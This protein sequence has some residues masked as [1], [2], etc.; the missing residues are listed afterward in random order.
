MH[1]DSYFSHS[2]FRGVA[3]RLLT[4]IGLVLLVVLGARAQSQL[5]DPNMVQG[6]PRM[7]GASANFVAAAD[8][9][10]SAPFGASPIVSL[11]SEQKVKNASTNSTALVLNAGD[12]KQ[13]EKSDRVITGDQFSP[14]NKRSPRA[15]SAAS[16][17]TK[18]ADQSKRP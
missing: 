14:E 10:T 5:T 3:N 16:L 12:S 9:I 15:A 1:D 7:D 11:Q 2:K 4:V 6:R 13:S 17:M 18:K 8:L